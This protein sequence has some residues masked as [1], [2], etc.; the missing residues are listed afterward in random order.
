MAIDINGRAPEALVEA[1]AQDGARRGLDSGQWHSAAAASAAA[2]LVHLMREAIKGVIR[3]HQ[4]QSDVIRGNQTP[5]R[6]SHPFPFVVPVHP[7]PIGLVLA[8]VHSVQPAGRVVIR[9][10]A[11]RGLN[12]ALKPTPGPA[13]NGRRAILATVAAGV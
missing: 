12:T 7:K 5:S 13:T 10:D 6:A 9:H 8:I 1:N 2:A 4:R 11:H 3:G